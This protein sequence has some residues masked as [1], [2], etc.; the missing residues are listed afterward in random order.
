MAHT[1]FLIVFTKIVHTWARVKSHCRNCDNFT[2]K[3][4]ILIF[5]GDLC[6]VSANLYR[7]STQGLG[8]TI[9]VGYLKPACPS[10]FWCKNDKSFRSTL[11]CETAQIEKGSC[12]LNSLPLSYNFYVFIMC[13]RSWAY[14]VLIANTL[15]HLKIIFIFILK[16]HILRKDILSVNNAWQ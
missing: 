3:C 10:F 16:A 8:F 14:L 11:Q 15:L 1:Y 9:K 6:V 13:L 12:R 5:I 2:T 7:I 4:R